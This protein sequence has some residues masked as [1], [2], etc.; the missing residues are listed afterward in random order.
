MTDMAYLWKVDTES[1][2]VHTVEEAREAL[3]EA[4]QAFVHQLQL[5][6][7]LF[8]IGH[9]VAELSETILEALE[10]I[11]R[12]CCATAALHTVP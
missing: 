12:G 5:H 9:S 7:V 2:H 11:L 3:G 6:E 4:R 10:C 8:E 1:I